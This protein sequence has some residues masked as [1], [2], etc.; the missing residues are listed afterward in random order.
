MLTWVQALGAQAAPSAGVRLWWEGCVFSVPGEHQ[1]VFQSGRA[2]LP[3]AMNESFS[4][5]LLS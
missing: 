2:T 5:F 1:T 4:L 3:P